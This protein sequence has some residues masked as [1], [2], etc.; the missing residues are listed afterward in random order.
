MQTTVINGHPG[1]DRKSQRVTCIHRLVWRC[2]IV[3]GTFSG[4]LAD[5][6]VPFSA[7]PRFLDVIFF[8][9][10][11]YFSKNPDFW[12]LIFIFYFK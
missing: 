4:V 9:Q 3:L 10:F 2:A 1:N 12:I 5:F 7:V 6:G 8:V 11:D